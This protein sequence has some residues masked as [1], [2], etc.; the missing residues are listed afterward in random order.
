[1]PEAPFRAYGLTLLFSP[2]IHLGLQ[3]LLTNFI[4]LVPVAMMIERKKSSS[5]LL[6]LFFILHFTILSLLVL[7][8]Q[9]RP[10][11]GLAFLGMS[12]VI[13]ALITYWALITRRYGMLMFAV[14]ILAM[15]WWQAQSSMTLLAH[16]LGLLVGACLFALGR[17]WQK[18][19]P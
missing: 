15:G 4:L 9:L 5:F 13:I 19:R 2:F 12:H 1:M 7:F 6:S 10:I 14:F 8:H 16:T 3:H 11:S 17:S 18:L